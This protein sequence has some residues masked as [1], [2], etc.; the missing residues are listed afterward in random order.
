MFNNN[1][2][3]PIHWPF[4][5]EALNGSVKNQLYE[6]ELSLICDQRYTIDDMKR[7]IEVLRKCV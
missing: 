3:T 4:E 2:F 1:I 5:S 6:N 7:Q